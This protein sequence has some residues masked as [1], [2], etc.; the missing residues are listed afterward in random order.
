MDIQSIAQHYIKK[1]II[2]NV[3]F[4]IQPCRDLS[5]LYPEF[6]SLIQ[7]GISDFNEIRPDAEV[8]LT[9]TYR[10]DP[11]QLIYYNS[12]ASKIRKNGMHHYGIAA[13]CAF[14]INGK[15]TYK[16]DY[17]NLRKCFK[18]IGLHILKE[19]DEGH[20]QLIPATASEQNVLRKAIDSAV[21]QFQSEN[22]LVVDGI[23]GKNTIKKAKELYVEVLA[24]N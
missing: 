8:V 19:W 12:G 14:K 16:G 5:L 9:E 11:L 10:S 1:L 17:K 18:E 3:Y 13:D 2:S 24:D 23:V 7:L 20:V 22:G 6:G 21:K 4:S 15:L